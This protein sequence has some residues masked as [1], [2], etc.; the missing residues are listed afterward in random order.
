MFGFFFVISQYFQFVQGLSPLNAAVRTLPLTGIFILVSPLSVTLTRRFGGRVTV[1]FGLLVGA[2]GFG[3][4][5][6][7]SPDSPYWF[8]VIPMMIMSGG[9]AMMMAQSSEAI[10]TSLPQD[11]AGVGSAVNDTTREVGGAIGI[12][13]MGSILAVGYRSGLGDVV[14][15][16]TPESAERVRDSIGQALAV[17]ADAPAEQARLITDAA[18]NAYTDGLALAFFVSAGLMVATAIVVA[19]F[20]AGDARAEQDAETSPI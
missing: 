11:K 12:A 2:L 8:I 7:L 3:M 16:L 20:H 17:A 1:T 14:D 15:T 19:V 9:M 10:V 5:G 13:V 4:F 6:L 18:A